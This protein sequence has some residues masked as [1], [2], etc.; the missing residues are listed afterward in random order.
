MPLEDYGRL[1]VFRFESL[2][3]PG[4][5][6]GVFTRRGGLSPA[7][8][9]S[10]NLG[11]MVGDEPARVRDNRRLALAAL[12]RAPESV[13]DV[14]Q[15]HSGEV[16]LAATPRREG[17]PQRADAILTDRAE[18]TLLMRFADCVPILLHDPV[19]QAIGIVHAGWLG[20]V[21][22]VARH[23]VRK[24]SEQYGTHPQDLL[25]GI[26]PSIA[27]HHYPVGPEVVDAIR[28]SLGEAAEAHLAPQPGGSMQLDLWSANE[29]LLREQGVEHIEIAGLCSA[30]DTDDWYSHRA[31]RG[32]TGRF[33]VLMA[34]A[35]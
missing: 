19:Q 8:W 2:S 30:C 12:G 20:T 35:A 34:L 9:S 15:V 21:R 1:R 14:W 33:G 16:V 11:A 31:E 29:Q 24:M 3:T 28:D 23:A 5:V 18:V 27:G 22:Q 13:F 6:H 32:R 4:V 7:P 17:A 25:V 26:G 10:L